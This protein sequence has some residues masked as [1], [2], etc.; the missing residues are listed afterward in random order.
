MMD[1][2][3]TKTAK[4]EKA[5]QILGKLLEFIICMTCF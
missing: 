3:I 4:P 1:R 5:I 2:A